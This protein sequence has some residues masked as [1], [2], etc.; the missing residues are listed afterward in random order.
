MSSSIFLWVVG[1]GLLLLIVVV[2]YNTPRAKAARACRAEEYRQQKEELKEKEK[3]EITKMVRQMKNFCKQRLVVYIREK[4]GRKS[5]FEAVLIRALL[6]EGVSVQFLRDNDGRAIA[7][8]DAEL[9]KDGVLA[10][11]GTS[12]CKEKTGGGY[13]DYDIGYIGEYQ[14]EVTYCDY[15]LLS[16]SSGVVSILGAGCQDRESSCVEDLANLII[17]DLASMVPVPLLIEASQ[18]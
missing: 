3:A 6:K 11:I 18:K 12:W 14:Y 13:E 4:D 15:R 16:A 9:L 7:N 2:L 8:A 1:L 17:R 5:S 10:L